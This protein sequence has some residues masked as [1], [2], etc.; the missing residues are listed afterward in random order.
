MNEKIYNYNVFAKYNESRID[1]F[2]QSHSDKTSRTKIQNLI[3]EGFVKLNDKTIGLLNTYRA[4]NSANQR[5]Y[6]DVGTTAKNYFT[7][8][9]FE[10][11]A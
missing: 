10:N 9:C 4:H 6:K 1:K 11:F 8:L 3:R 2:L 7:N 5:K